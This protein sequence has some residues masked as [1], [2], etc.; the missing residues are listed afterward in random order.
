VPEHQELDLL[1]IWSATSASE[2]TAEQE[3]QE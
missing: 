3:V 2:E 1:L